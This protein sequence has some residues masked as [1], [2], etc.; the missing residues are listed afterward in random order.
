MIFFEFIFLVV[1]KIKK[2]KNKKWL[3]NAIKKVFRIRIAFVSKKKKN[4]IALRVFDPSTVHL[5]FRKFNVD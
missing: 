5:E 3:K 1:K 2:L 4:R